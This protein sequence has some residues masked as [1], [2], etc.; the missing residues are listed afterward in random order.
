MRVFLKAMALFVI[1]VPAALAGC[2]ASPEDP[3]AL[4]TAAQ[5]D[6]GAEGFYQAS[7]KE[8][9]T[10]ETPAYQQPSKEAPAYQQPSKETPAY[11]QPSKETP[12]YQQ[13]SQET[14]G[15]GNF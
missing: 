1:S 2:A 11:Q 9:P 6:K 4:G 13:P 7:P 14:P 15:Q 12:A 10:K 3:A 8:T 5:A